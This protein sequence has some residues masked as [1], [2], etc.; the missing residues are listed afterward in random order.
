MLESVSK[1]VDVQSNIAIPNQPTAEESQPQKV[2]DYEER[3][4][5]FEKQSASYLVSSS[6]E[7]TPRAKSPIRITPETD[8]D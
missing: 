7:A 4:L 3:V 5:V 6:Q 2:E 8:R 1:S